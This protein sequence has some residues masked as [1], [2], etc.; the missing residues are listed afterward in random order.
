MLDC[1]L[2]LFSKFDL[3]HIAG[4]LYKLSDLNKFFL[5]SWDLANRGLHIQEGLLDVANGVIA[6]LFASLNQAVA[7]LES[8]LGQSLFQFMGLDTEHRSIDVVVGQVQDL[9]GSYMV[10]I[11]C[12]T[13]GLDVSLGASVSL[14]ELFIIE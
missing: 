1:L 3:G 2:K 10:F 7:K 11:N 4:N 12:L 5:I 6:P 9:I 13:D 8:S 14:L